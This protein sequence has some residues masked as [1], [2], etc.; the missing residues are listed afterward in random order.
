MGDR[1]LNTWKSLLEQ[2]RDDLQK[3]C[4]RFGIDVNKLLKQPKC[5]NQEKLYIQFV[6]YKE[7]Q[8][9]WNDEKPAKILMTISR[10]ND[11]LV[12]DTAKDIK[13]YLDR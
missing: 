1:I 12:F 5:Y 6:D 3:E 11:T 8:F 13:D 10:I 7:S 2:H 4:D 9:E